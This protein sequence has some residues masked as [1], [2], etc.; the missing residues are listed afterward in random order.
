MFQGV[1]R[2]VNFDVVKAVIVASPGFVKDA[3]L[4]Y[5][6]S[7]AVK[8]DNKV[9]LDNRGKFLPVH[10][11][12]GFKH[13]LKEVLQEPQVQAKLADTKAAEEVR[14]L[15]A[16]YKMLQSDPLRACYGFKHVTKAVEAQA[17]ETLLIS[18]RL[19]RAQD[20]AERKKYVTVVD[21]V[22]EF[23]GDVKIFSSMHVSGEQLDQ[24]T[25]LC[26]TLRFPMQELEDDS[27]EDSD[28]SQSDE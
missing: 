23:G 20:V 16:F 8:T 24:L 5:M 15:E 11:S 1:L 13:S 2:H 22:R 19:F 18:D 21:E 26:A 9:I 10:S 4:E 27:D 14:A 7:T 6:I 25:G 28:D 17:V 3:F 12:S